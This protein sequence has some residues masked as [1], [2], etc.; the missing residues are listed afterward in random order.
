MT[1]TTTELTSV[2]KL[3]HDSVKGLEDC[4]SHAKVSNFKSYL[5]T[6]VGERKS[7]I[8][9]LNAFVATNGQTPVD[10]GTVA[11]PLHRFY[12]DLKSYVTD[13]NNADIKKEI[14][15]GDETLIKAYNEAITAETN[16]TIK[17]TLD[18]QLKE[19]HHELVKLTQTASLVN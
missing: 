8:T 18:K 2:L 6:L 11:G 7:F 15:R 13:Q 16:A 3:L 10:S 9:Q 4:A 17:D 1:T 5:T 14:L 12:I 19:I